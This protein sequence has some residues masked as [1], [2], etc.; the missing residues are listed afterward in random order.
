[1][2]IP[3]GEKARLRVIFE[4]LD[5][6]FGEVSDSGIIMQEFFG[7]YQLSSECATSFGCRLETMLQNAI[8]NEYL[9]KASKNDLLR[10]Q[11]WVSLR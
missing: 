2:L 8:D 6:L 4:K 7:A 3:F 5:I 1:M 9:D 11:F 10:H